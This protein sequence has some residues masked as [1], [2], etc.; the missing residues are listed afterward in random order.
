[1]GCC[2]ALGAVHPCRGEAGAML[3]GGVR[4]PAVAL[5]CFG[6][7]GGR[8][9]GWVGWAKRPSRPVGRLG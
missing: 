6:A 1:V 9:A 3:G 5:P 2:V 4:P 7:G 8:K